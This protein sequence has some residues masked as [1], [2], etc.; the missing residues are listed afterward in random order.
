MCSTVSPSAL[1]WARSRA[2]YIEVPRDRTRPEDAG[3]T[4]D[5]RAALSEWLKA[6]GAQIRQSRVELVEH[7]GEAQYPQ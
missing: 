3:G 5:L 4:E 7:Q 1:L 6:G 2:S